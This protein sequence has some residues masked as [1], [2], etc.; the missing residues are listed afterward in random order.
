LPQPVA[1]VTPPD[2]I[3]GI[4]FFFFF[5]EC[6]KQNAAYEGPIIILL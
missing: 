4:F 6:W 2:V 3:N 5:F 1:V